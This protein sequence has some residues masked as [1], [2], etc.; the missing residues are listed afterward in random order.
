[1]SGRL[2]LLRE[3]PPG[4]GGVERVAHDLAAHWHSQG[5]ACTVFSLGAQPDALGLPDPLPVAYPRR[6]LPSLVLGRLVLPLPSRGLW[7]L[8]FAPEPLHA[9]LPCPGVLAVALLARLLRP[10]R[11]ISL[12][13]HSFL[14]PSPSLAGRLFTAYQALALA[15]LPLFRCVITTSPLLRQALIDSGAQPERVRVL[16]CCLPAAAEQAAD[17]AA[18]ARLQVP[19]AGAV[20]GSEP[21]PEPTPFRLLSISRLDS[22][23]RVDWL[24]EALARLRRT[25]PTL[26]LQLDVV[27]D[28]PDR[29]VLERLAAALAPGQVRFH[30]RLDEAAKQLRLAQA[31]LLVLAANRSNEAFGIVQLE[32][33]ASA[34]PALAFRHPRSGMHWVSELPCLPWAGT[35]EV[36]PATIA[37]LARDPLL[38][39]RARREARQRYSECFARAVWLQTLAICFQP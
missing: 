35:P 7:R 30:G 39:A 18:Q 19:R 23:K 4:Y 21:S 5:Q 20:V 3:W 24:I 17:A 26:P 28:G 9:H 16:P 12:H 29:P 32:A 27:G 2:Q 31:D 38:L 36:L 33:M 37:A 11:A 6:R 14:E 25:A 34:V 13:W 15:V 10:G 22:Y 1:M 8:L